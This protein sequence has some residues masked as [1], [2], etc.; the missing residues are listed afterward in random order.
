MQTQPV[1]QQAFGLTSIFVYLN[2]AMAI[3]S[4]VTNIIAEFND[5]VETS[6]E[7]LA[8]YIA[9]ILMAINQAFPRVRISNEVVLQCCEAIAEI[10]NDRRKVVVPVAP[11]KKG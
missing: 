2:I 7:D 8:V 5:P 11:A 10:M 4:S 1:P 3:A 6:G 9:P